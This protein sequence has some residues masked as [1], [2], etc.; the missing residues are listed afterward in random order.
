MKLIHMSD[1]HIGKRLNDFSLIDDQKYIL[2]EIVKIID[3]EKPDGI[4]IAGDVYD[5]SVPSAEAVEVL[6]DF[7]V[8]LAKMNQQ[9]FIISGNHD[10]PERLAF[11]NRI[12]D[13]FGIHI[14]SAYG[15]H[16]EPITLEDEY[17]PVNIYMLPF[18]KPVNVRSHF[19]GKEINSYTDGVKAAIEEMAID[20]SVRNLLMTHQF[21]TGA[22]RSESEE[23]SIGG[24]DNV[25]ASVMADFDY[26][27]LGHI[28]GPQDMMEGKIRYCGTPLKYSFSEAHH[29]KSLTVVELKEKGTIAIRTIPLKPYRDMVEIRGRFEEVMARGEAG[30]AK[31]SKDFVRVTLTDED[32]IPDV[33]GKLRKHYENIMRI[34]YDNTRTKSQK[35]IEGTDQVEEKTPM[36]LF[37]QLY[38]MQNN[39]KMTSAQEAIVNEL[40]TKIWGK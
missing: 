16:I 17:G 36:E 29:E 32:Y 3:E 30:G 27:A 31:A 4:L 2:K 39:Q 11:G 19:E 9:V 37:S 10:S 34:D 15:G 1:L 13:N 38:E 26:V 8:T 18:I 20:Q 6:D 12:M 23:I 14:S 28:H 5:K 24:S 22:K 40:I 7:L 33:M 21:V 35:T 25:D